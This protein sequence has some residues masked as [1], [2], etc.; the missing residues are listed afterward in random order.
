MTV[1]EKIQEIMEWSNRKK[2]TQLELAR[3]SG[4]S[5]SSLNGYIHGDRKI[6]VDAAQKIADA[7]NVSLWTLLNGE[8]L[9]VT[10]MDLTERERRL[11]SGYRRLNDEQRAAVDQLLQ[12]MGPDPK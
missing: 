5:K 9:A 4:I 10:S 2:L 7:L 11:V 3:L 1:P 8:A 12:A 6:T